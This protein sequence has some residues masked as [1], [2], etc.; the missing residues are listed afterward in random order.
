ML[1][2]PFCWRAIAASDCCQANRAT[3]FDMLAPGSQVTIEN[4]DQVVSVPAG[5]S[6]DCAMREIAAGHLAGRELAPHDG[7]QRPRQQFEFPAGK[8]AIG[9]GQQFSDLEGQA[10]SSANQ[11]RRGG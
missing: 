9:A 6:F 5:E 3:L 7:D 10:R 4:H 1:Q 8:R 2:P 11:L